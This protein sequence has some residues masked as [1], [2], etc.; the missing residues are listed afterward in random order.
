MEPT[1]LTTDESTETDAKLNVSEDR[2]A[3][4]LSCS[5]DDSMGSDL[6]EET[7]AEL[8]AMKVKSPL[9]LDVLSEALDQ[10]KQNGE[11][12]A[13]LV[14]AKGK[15]PVLPEDG[16]LEWAGEFFTKGYYV[17]PETKQ[18][19]YRRRAASPDV[20]EGQL[21][22]KVYP[23]RPG[24]D[25]CDV[26]GRTIR[27]PVPKKANL[28]GGPNVVW[29]DEDSSFRAGCAGRVK[30]A[31]SNIEVQQ[32]MCISGDVGT[33]SG[34]VRHEGDVSIGGDVISQFEVVAKGDVEIRGVVGACDIEC[35][36]HLTVKGGI[37]GSKDK[38]V[39][40]KDGVSAKYIEGATIEAQGDVHAELDI[41]LSA[42]R[43]SG[44]VDVEG[45]IVGGSIIAAE[46]IR[47]GRTG[48]KEFTKTVLVAGVDFRVLES[49]K[50]IRAKKEEAKTTLKKLALERKKI[51]V[52]A[53]RLSEDKKEAL[54]NVMFQIEE[55]KAMTEELD[56]ED[57]KMHKL[58][59]AHRD[60]QIEI[61][62]DV[63]A[64]TVF[65][66]LDSQHEVTD[67]LRGPLV[68]AID[69]ATG[70]IALSSTTEKE[71]E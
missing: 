7:Q 34:N 51:E 8:E 43:T 31:G 1:Q 32:A 14:V 33:E 62:G 2:M 48:S 10:A 4:L 70:E 26:F 18:V 27:V 63:Y 46:G 59:Y 58:V 21:L 56:E 44:R 42:I 28:R 45:R 41:I 36:G 12:I 69:T 35:G 52:S 13:G 3:V 49:I 40:A 6:V 9:E 20:R 30:L 53:V 68:A 39:K 47:V 19:D 23:P 50:D 54:T 16:K 38:L 71:P 55:I 65:R 29:S 57:K 67:A 22:V 37:R 66:V 60:A 61:S 17:D 11:N 5:V 24:E 64:G 25:G 15:S